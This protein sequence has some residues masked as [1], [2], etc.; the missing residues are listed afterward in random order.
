LL[1]PEEE[2]RPLLAEIAEIK[3]QVQRTFEANNA[4]PVF[5][6]MYRNYARA[7]HGQIQAIPIPKSRAGEVEDMFRKAAKSEGWDWESGDGEELLKNAKGREFI[8]IDLP[9]GKV[10]VHF[11]E[12]K[13]NLQFAR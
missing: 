6:D 13:F 4:V 5:C 7:Q 9:N 11:I 2:A 12:G 8:R 3:S 10:L 1:L